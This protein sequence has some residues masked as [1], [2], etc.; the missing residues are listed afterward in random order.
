MKRVI[1]SVVL[2]LALA[3]A[4]PAS[5]QQPRP[6]VAAFTA[7]ITGQVQAVAPQS[8]LLVLRRWMGR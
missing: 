7:E 2:T 4:L 5:G 8:G 1:L 6:I 3:A